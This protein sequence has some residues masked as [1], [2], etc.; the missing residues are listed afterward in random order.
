MADKRGP[1]VRGKE[2]DILSVENDGTGIG[3]EIPADS[4]EQSG[5]PCPVGADYRNKFPVVQMKTQVFDGSFL[6]DRSRIK[7]LA[8]LI[9]IKHF[10]RSPSSSSNPVFS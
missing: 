1:F 4:V 2:R 7:G 9:Y 5:F 3:I 6:I 8:Y 10:R